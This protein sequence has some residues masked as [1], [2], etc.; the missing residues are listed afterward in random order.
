MKKLAIY[1]E[2]EKGEVFEGL[3]I[4]GEDGRGQNA[5]KMEMNAG[6]SDG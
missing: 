3:E 4:D 1:Y 5:E 2:K 6:S